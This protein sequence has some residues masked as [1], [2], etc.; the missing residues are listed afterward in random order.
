[1][2]G[3]NNIVQVK[4]TTQTTVVSVDSK[5]LVYAMQQ[6]T[7]YSGAFYYLTNFAGSNNSRDIFKTIDT[8]QVGS[9]TLVFWYVPLIVLI[10]PLI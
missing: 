9:G 7:H 6:P 3:N 5:E 10:L 2:E 4:C 8:N 1:M